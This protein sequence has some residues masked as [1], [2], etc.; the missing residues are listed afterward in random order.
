[1]IEA[2]RSFPRIK[3][4]RDMQHPVYASVAKW[5]D[6]WSKTKE[7]LSH[8][9]STIMLPPEQLWSVTEIRQDSGHSREIR[10]HLCLWACVG[11]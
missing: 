8:L 10:R 11:G 9:P 5:Y 1:M 6:V 2:Q 7:D 4:C 3:G